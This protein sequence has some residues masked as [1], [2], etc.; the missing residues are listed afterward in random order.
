MWGVDDERKEKQT[1][2]RVAG[3]PAVFRSHALLTN[4]L[5]QVI[6]GHSHSH[7]RGDNRD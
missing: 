4:T 7:T 5:W 6:L 1:T 2:S 3:K